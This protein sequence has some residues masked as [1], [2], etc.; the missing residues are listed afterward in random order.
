MAP[1]AAARHDPGRGLE[2]GELAAE[3]ASELPDREAMSLLD[4]NIDLGLD[5]DVT[6]P[7]AGAIAANA[8]VAA[9]IDASV[10]ANVGLTDSIAMASADQDATIVQTLNG[11]AN[12]TANQDAT[13]DQGDDL[14]SSATGTP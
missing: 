3:A 12:A 7:I 11:V 2:P 10:A 1:D 8:N 4:L 6:A 13:I 14:G 9:P 5:G